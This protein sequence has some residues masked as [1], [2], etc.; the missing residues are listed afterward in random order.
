M[1][2][3]EFRG[4]M[5]GE[6]I[7]GSLISYPEDSNYFIRE[8]VKKQGSDRYETYLIEDSETLG[9]FTGLSD[10]NG[11]K[12]YEGDILKFKEYKNLSWDEESFKSFSLE[13]RKGKLIDHY[14]SQV[15][16]EEGNFLF[17]ISESCQCCLSACFGNQLMQS[18]IYDFEIIGNIHDNPELLK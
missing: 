8:Q 11:I 17:D 5:S 9:Q 12:I 14:I 18:P 13:E 6:W 15:Y 16:W 3:I 7:F 2:N 1:R 4:K 10:K